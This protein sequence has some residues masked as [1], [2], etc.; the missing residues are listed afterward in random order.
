MI[1][2]TGLHRLI[3]TDTGAVTEREG[4]SVEVPP[5]HRLRAGKRYE[6]IVTNASNPRRLTKP[7]TSSLLPDRGRASP[8][9]PM[10]EGQDDA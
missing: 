5:Y 3:V 4:V 8:V 10:N 9:H 7:H 1:L 6:C 2:P